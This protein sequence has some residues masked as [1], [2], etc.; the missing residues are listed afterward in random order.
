VILRAELE[1][2]AGFDGE[3]SLDFRGSVEIIGDGKGVPGGVVFDLGVGEMDEDMVVLVL[4]ECGGRVEDG[5]I[6]RLHAERRAIVLK[7]VGFEVAEGSALQDVET[8]A[9]GVAD[10]GMVDG[11]T[12]A[13]PDLDG[14]II[15]AALGP[16]SSTVT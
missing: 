5:E 8:V 12:R 10:G 13:D 4:A 6:V 9:G 16:A 2:C 3:M 7:V 1:A 15:A 14:C 11:E